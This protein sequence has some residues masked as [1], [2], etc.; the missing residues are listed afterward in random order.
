MLVL[1]NGPREG[2]G[3]HVAPDA[4]S[5]DNIFNFAMIKGVSRLMMFRLIPEVMNGTH[6]RFK[7]VKLGEF[8]ELDLK[9]DRPMA[10]HTDGEIYVGFDSEVRELSVR[11]LPSELQLIS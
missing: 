7:Q 5:N 10:I 11:L 3:F 4:R 9:F 1:C 2:G 6:G 8:R